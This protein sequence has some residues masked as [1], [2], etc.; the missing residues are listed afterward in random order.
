MCIKFEVG[1]PLLHYR[2][3]RSNFYLKQTSRLHIETA[4]ICRNT[5]NV[6]AMIQSIF[7]ATY[8]KQMDLR[9]SKIERC[10]YARLGEN[11]NISINRD[12]CEQS[13]AEEGTWILL[14][15]ALAEVHGGFGSGT[16]VFDPQPTAVGLL[17]SPLFAVRV[18]IQFGGIPNAYTLGLAV[19]AT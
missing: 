4:R 16:S 5:Q 18:F 2:N 12:K 6:F 15:R 3:L 11:R 17:T 9:L 8:T 13:T 14:M 10:R 1:N 19:V 7:H